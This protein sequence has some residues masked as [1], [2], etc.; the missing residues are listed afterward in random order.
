MP[1]SP[2]CAS[3]LRAVC[4]LTARTAAAKQ[5]RRAART[6]ERASRGR[7][8]MHCVAARA[9]VFVERQHACAIAR[10][11]QQHQMHLAGPARARVAAGQPD[12]RAEGVRLPEAQLPRERPALATRVLKSK[13]GALA[14]RRDR[15]AAKRLHEAEGVH[16]CVWGGVEKLGEGSLEQSRRA[17]GHGDPC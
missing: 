17:R 5:P 12:R 4:A 16:P 11:A 9:T 8:N 6:L 10:C 2:A 13:G 1:A 3:G 7:G 14:E 15:G